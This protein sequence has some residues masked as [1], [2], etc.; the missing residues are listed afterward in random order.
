[1]KPCVLLHQEYVFRSCAG[2]LLS[3]VP[4]KVLLTV[5]SS[6]SKA[7]KAQCLLMGY[8]VRVKIPNPNSWEGDFTSSAHHPFACK[9][10]PFFTYIF[11]SCLFPT[12]CFS[13]AYTTCA[14]I[15]LLTPGRHGPFMQQ[16]GD[17]YQIV[18]LLEGSRRSVVS[19]SL[20]LEESE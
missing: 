9:I 3:N 11:L 13:A 15:P 4:E 1:M 2:S 10:F 14:K 6:W 7:W 12:T 17:A 5:L 8:M 16:T 18:H 19:H 20:E